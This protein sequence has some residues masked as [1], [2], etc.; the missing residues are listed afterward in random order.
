MWG[1]SAILFVA[2]FCP[3]TVFAS[4]NISANAA[5][6]WAWNDFVGWINFYSNSDVTVTSTSLTGDASSSAGIIS[7][8]CNGSLNIPTYNVCGASNYQVLNDGAGNLSG[9]AWNDMY[10]WISFWC[11]NG[12]TGC[13]TSPYRVTINPTT[14]DFSGYAW[15]DAIGWISFNCSGPG[16]CATSNYKVNTTWTESSTSG[17]LDSQT[18]DAGIAGGTQLNSVLWHGFLPVGTAVGFQF[19]VSNSSSGPWNFTGPD[20][21]SNSTSSYWGAYVAPSSSIPLT[22]P[23]I[24]TVGYGL[25]NNFRYFRYR[26]TL[27]S[28]AAQTMT[29]R[30]DDVIVNWSP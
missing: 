27:F 29:P 16:I 9:W 28:N 14:G 6:H 25:Y 7:L 17:Y 3:A 2:F 23:S 13:G 30:V 26:I 4:T 8:N 19:A 21:I 18:F 24:S 1:I 20:G 5:S 15:N 11:G 22:N 12:G 10:G